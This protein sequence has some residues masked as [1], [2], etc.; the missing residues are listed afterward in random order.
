MV[1]KPEHSTE[2]FRRWGLRN[3]LAELLIERERECGI[4]KD[5]LKNVL[6]FKIGNI[7]KLSVNKKF[8]HDGSNFASNSKEK[9]I[10]HHFLFVVLIVF[11]Y[12]I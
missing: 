9:K 12:A 6:R 5:S 8:M 7:R 3:I 1:C 10:Q 2:H 4:E 11:F